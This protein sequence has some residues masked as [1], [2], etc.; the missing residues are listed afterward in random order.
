MCPHFKTSKTAPVPKYCC[1]KNHSL[2]N[3]ILSVYTGELQ[4]RNEQIKSLSAQ[5]KISESEENNKSTALQSTQEQLARMSE[6]HSHTSMAVQD[7]EVSRYLQILIKF[8]F[9]QQNHF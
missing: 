2:L 5:L 4:S 7:L 1:E 8:P 3:V 6:K 9:F